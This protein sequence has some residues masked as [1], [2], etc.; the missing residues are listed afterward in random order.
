MEE[1]QVMEPISA[2]L[3]S[4]LQTRTLPN[5]SVSSQT[6]EE[7]KLLVLQ[8][9]L[10]ANRKAYDLGPMS[11]EQL[12]LYTNDLW[13]CSL[14][15]VVRALG[16]CRRSV[17][18][19]FPKIADIVQAIEGSEE[20]QK[21]TQCAR[22]SIAFE[23]AREIAA[24][25]VERDVHGNYRLCPS[26]GPVKKYVAED[27]PKDY[28]YGARPI[29]IPTIDPEIEYAVRLCGGWGRLKM[30]DQQSFPFY[31]REFFEQFNLF[32]EVEKQRLQIGTRQAGRLIRELHK[33]PEHARKLHG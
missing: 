8:R 28:F 27:D 30:L 11:D 18:Y 33:G 5:E 10:Q 24:K 26:S 7:Q 22:A 31:Q 3:D 29:P 4:P 17:P 9:L 21:Q 14:E 20:E 23:K 1:T 16:V 2:E 32:G 13:D 25:F 6:S 12:K 15:D 19:G